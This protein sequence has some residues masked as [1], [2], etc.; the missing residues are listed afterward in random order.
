[1][2]FL[3]RSGWGRMALHEL[4]RECAIRLGTRSTRSVFQ[5]RFP[6]ARRF[7]QPDAPRDHS[8]VNAFTEMLPHVGNDLLAKVG[9]R[10]EHR[11][12]DPAQFE[13]L[14]RPSIQNLLDE[15]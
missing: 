7:A 10:V 14:V 13:T 1:M 9:A 6:E 5:N 12:D 3:E 4:S 2:R 15:P 8:L 11:H